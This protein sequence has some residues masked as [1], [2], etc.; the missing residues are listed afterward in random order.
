[1]WFSLFVCTTTRAI[2]L[3]AMENLSLNDLFLAFCK[4]AACRFVKVG[5]KKTAV[6]QLV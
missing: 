3:E 1:M 6:L 5:M 2:Y 4:F